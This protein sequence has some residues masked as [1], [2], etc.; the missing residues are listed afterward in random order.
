MSGLLKLLGSTEKAIEKASQNL[1]ES[2]QPLKAQTDKL[3]SIRYEYSICSLALESIEYLQSIE[4]LLNSKELNTF[5]F[6]DISIAFSYVKAKIIGLDQPSERKP[7]ESEYD[8]LNGFFCETL[9]NRFTE[10]IKSRSKDELTLL[11]H[12]ITLM[13]IQDIVYSSF[14]NNFLSPLINT[15]NG[16]SSKS[17][18]NASLVLPK[19]IEYLQTKEN[20]LLFIIESSPSSFDFLF[21]SFWP[22]VTQWLELQITF[23]I[24]NIT[25][26]FQCYV[27]LN[28]FFSLC[29]S[30]CRSD[31]ATQ[32]ILNCNRSKSIFTKLR[33]D[34]YGQ[35]ISNKLCNDAE[36]LFTAPLKQIDDDNFALSIS[37]NF[38]RFYKEIFH[39]D[40]FVIEQSKDFAI[41]SMKLIS[42]LSRFATINSSKQMKPLFS[43]DLHNIQQFLTKYTPLH[44]LKVM[45]IPI[46]SLEET[47]NSLKSEITQDL[48]QNCIAKIQYIS[49][50]NGTSVQNSTKLKPSP[51]AVAALSPY[52]EWASKEGSKIANEEMLTQIVKALFENFYQLSETLLTSIKTDL[53]K[54]LVFRKNKSSS[55]DFEGVKSNLFN[56][57]GVKAKLKVDLEYIANIARGKHV[58]VDSLEIYLKLVQFLRPEETK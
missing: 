31:E 11:F 28:K 22:L 41:V 25:E 32:E 57:E 47:S 30:L 33:L 12:A 29:E 54:L 17:T 39:E 34:I 2:M 14:S 8:R 53:D 5:N 10:S 58:N 43:Y 44:L 35:L 37:P 40:K 19:I 6:I 48:I 16:A 21:Y 56:I 45:E 42:S 9:L 36:S 3:H 20:D 23:P 15:L 13:G 38:V 4:T 46:K 18:S 24:G 7:I 26:Q 55:V 49:N 50:M 52:I 1:Q 27:L 51:N